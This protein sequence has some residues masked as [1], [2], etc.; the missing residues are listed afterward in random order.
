MIFKRA[1]FGF[2]LPAL[3]WFG[4]ID[5]SY[6]ALEICEVELAKSSVFNIVHSSHRAIGNISVDFVG[7]CCEMHGAK[8]S[9][10]FDEGGGEFSGLAECAVFFNFA[11]GWIKLSDHNFWFLVFVVNI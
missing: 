2:L 8:L 10:G 6:R 3:R 1:G 4:L 11:L 5:L 7:A 9:V